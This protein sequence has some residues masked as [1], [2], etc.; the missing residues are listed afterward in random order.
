[1]LREDV[2]C[3]P[4]Q[5]TDSSAF[6]RLALCVPYPTHRAQPAPSAAH[7][8]PA[9]ASPLPHD[10]QE[11]AA[12]GGGA[13]D[14]AGG[15]DARDAAGG[16][17]AG[18]SG[19][20]EISL[21]LEDF[22]CL[23]D[24]AQ[25]LLA[26]FIEEHL[27]QTYPAS[28]LELPFVLAAIQELDGVRVTRVHSETKDLVE[29]TT[30]DDVDEADV[31]K[32]WVELVD[33]TVTFNIQD[34]ARRQKR[35]GS[36]SAAPAP[37]LG[38]MLTP[39][40]SRDTTYEVAEDLDELQEPYLWVQKAG[41]TS[42]FVNLPPLATSETPTFKPSAPDANAICVNC[43]FE[44]QLVVDDMESCFGCERELHSACVRRRKGKAPA[45]GPHLK[46]RDCQ[47]ERG[48]TATLEPWTRDRRRKIEAMTAQRRCQIQKKNKTS[49]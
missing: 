12:G 18:G 43:G 41:N 4:G 20:D 46:C 11:D 2:S 21:S 23:G 1:M 27:Q 26:E 37:V 40:A 45:F 16:G 39:A 17:D 32:L 6:P 5:R 24:C 28:K 7:A 3:G 42:E 14:A 48:K 8:G 49:E 47:A 30:M 22:E 31:E 10:A 29:V 36:D 34:G 33:L 13:T 9:S 38:S 15:R 19:R 35:Q 25:M 44:W